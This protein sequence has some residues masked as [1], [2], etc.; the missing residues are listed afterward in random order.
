[1]NEICYITNADLR[2]SANQKSWPTQKVTEE[3]LVVALAGL[4]VLA[5]RGHAV[6]DEKGHGFIDSQ[7]SGMEVFRT[8]DRDTP[9]IVLLTTW[10]YSHHILHGLISHRG[11][12]LTIANWSGQYPGLVGLLNLN[13]SLTKADVVYSTLFSESFEDELFV[14]KLQEWIDTGWVQHNSDHVL[15]ASRL[16]VPP[17]ASSIGQRL[18]RQ[19]K[20][21][22][23]IIG[24]FDEGCMG[25]YNAI[26]PD[27][28]LHPTGIFK[29]RLSQSA[30]YHET[31]E[32]AQADAEQA[33]R[34]LLDR[35]VTFHF[36]SDEATELTERQVLLQLRMYIAAVRIADDF[37]CSAIGIQYQQGLKDL[38]PASDLAEGLLNNVER[39]PVFCRQGKR[40]LFQGVAV[41]HFNE[42]DE[43][44]A[45]DTLMTNRL[46]TEL[47]FDP[48][49]TLHDIRW[50]DDFEGDFVWV[51]EISGAAPASHFIGGYQGASSMRQPP[52]YF[53]LGGA[54]LRGVSRP[55]PIVWSRIYVADGILKADIGR[56]H[57]V[58]LP[59]DETLRR[60]HA[61]SFEWPI[62][63]AVLHG[64]SREQMMA[65][66]KSN[67]IHVVYAPTEEDADF[68]MGAKIAFLETLGIEV[69][70]CGTTKLGSTQN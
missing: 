33:Y 1:M 61:T 29:E 44:A 65:R 57:V 23:A 27:H 6:D 69:W 55:G 43:C 19:L 25:M 36:G 14:R 45:V 13:A 49:N 26:V 51:F 24:V 20:R 40:E 2:L 47:G 53:K 52:M 4:G 41:P 28:L 46:W 70:V 5:N 35:G 48:A 7:K 21:E 31:L 34:W 54:T 60:W 22:K 63:H 42:V 37:G 15:A 12:V 3:K 8:I 56:A 58:E 30:L 11:P 39:P 62:M 10:Q 59:E 32:V 38:L 66:H 18:G 9:L 17:Q 68:A 67:H 64:I 50:G 16:T